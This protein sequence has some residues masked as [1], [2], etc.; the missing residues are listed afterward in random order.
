MFPSKFLTLASDVKEE[1]TTLQPFGSQV[2]ILST[3]YG[4]LKFIAPVDPIGNAHV[5]LSGCF[6]DEG[7][8]VIISRHSMSAGIEMS[9]G[10]NYPIVCKLRNF[11]KTLLGLDENLT[12]VWSIIPHRPFTIARLTKQKKIVYDSEAITSIEE[13]R[14]GGDELQTVQFP[15]KSTTMDVLSRLHNLTIH[16]NCNKFKETLKCLGIMVPNSDLMLFYQNCSTCSSK[17]QGKTHVHTDNDYKWKRGGIAQT[18]ITDPSIKGI[19]GYKH[20]SVIYDQSTGF[21]DAEAI[22]QKDNSFN[23]I[24]NYL[25]VNPHIS[26]LRSDNAGEYTSE[27]MMKTLSRMGVGFECTAPGGSTSV[28][29]AERSNKTIKDKLYDAMRCIGFEDR[30]E[31]WPW[32][33]KSAQ[34]SINFS[35]STSRN[36]IP[37]QLRSNILSAHHG[38][39][40]IDVIPPPFCFN[41]V[42]HFKTPRDCEGIEQ[43][44]NGFREGL[45]LSFIHSGSCEIISPQN[46]QVVRWI[47]HPQHVSLGNQKRKE[48]ISH[49][50]RWCLGQEKT[51]FF[52]NIEKP[53]INLTDEANEHNLTEMTHPF[54]P[55]G[56]FQKLKK[57]GKENSINVIRGRTQH[58]QHNKLNNQLQIHR[59]LAPLSTIVFSH[60]DADMVAV[61]I[62][63]KNMI[64]VNKVD[65]GSKCGDSIIMPVNKT[66]NNRRRAILLP[67]GKIHKLTPSK[68]EVTGRYFKDIGYIAPD[69]ANPQDVRSG[70]FNLSDDKEWNCLHNNSVMELENNIPN[71]IKAIKT[72]FRRTWKQLPGN[73]RKAKTRFVACAT[74]DFRQV[75][76]A[77]EMPASWIRR[78][79]VTFGLSRG[80]KAATIDIQTAFLLVPLPDDRHIYIQLPSSLPNAALNLKYQPNG[81][82]KLK[83]SLY[84]LKESPLLFNEFLMEKLKPLGWNRAF[85][86]VFFHESGDGILMAYVDDI[87]VLSS[88]PTKSLHEIS[89]IIKCSDLLPVN[90]EPQRHVGYEITSKETFIFFDIQ[91]YIN[92]L[93]DF[94]KEIDQLGQ[95]YCLK[96]LSPNNLPVLHDE[97]ELQ[98]YNP[99]HIHLF[100]RAI[101][102]LCWLATC[103]PA[104]CSRHGELASFTHKPSPKLFRILKGTMNELRSIGLSTL[105]YQKITKPEFR[106]W[107]DCAVHAHRGRRGWIL[108]AADV[109]W[110]L[111]IRNNLI[112]WKSARDRLKHASSTAG[113]VNAIL[114]ALEET[115]DCLSVV[116]TMY[117][118]STLRILSDSMSGILQIANGGSTIKSKTTA[119]YINHLLTRL[120]LINNGIEHVPGEIQLADP[121]TK[122]KQLQWYSHYDSTNIMS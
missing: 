95:Q 6:V 7:E 9:A 110:P 26:T 45:F 91:P 79:G 96:P 83:K 3:H 92:T 108:Q 122:V 39:K 66:F 54:P 85:P 50:L 29:G 28:G 34:C 14:S 90:E 107:V 120:P 53:S 75:D 32:F 57:K 36:A 67:S 73:E 25:A 101:G 71:G 30:P 121:L 48:S 111:T 46:E 27:K 103:H 84:G 19:H 47:V 51:R 13:H 16:P 20:I 17:P 87:L 78:L 1:T 104:I 24:L 72:R 61:T 15:P 40:S 23:H 100:Q 80:W 55:I 115:A 65:D 69:E 97:T 62:P 99:E 2:T 11:P 37:S 98:V 82:Y 49:H 93:P 52:E 112:H 106:L 42:V 60:S 58:D 105:S 77:T 8:E 76:T 56:Q 86:G 94:A 38:R 113:E 59:T 114:Q 41:D 64:T 43:T 89:H 70:S 21:V 63:H 10:K 22:K 117:P 118:D 12:Q 31:L 68:K 5:E 74:N 116:S 102:A 18:D 4:T 119:S 81:I 88:D 33:V 35:Y 44:P 109:S